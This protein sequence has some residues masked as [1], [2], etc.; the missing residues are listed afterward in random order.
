L[1]VKGEPKMDEISIITLIGMIC[2]VLSVAMLYFKSINSIDR[3]LTR[4]ETKTDLFWGMVEREIPRLLKAPT[5]LE[6]DDLLDK[7]TV[8]KLTKKDAIRLKDILEKE[9]DGCNDDKILACTL[10]LVRVEQIIMEGSRR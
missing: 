5:H 2:T 4:L 1:E 9:M 6:M 7:M 3:R 8:S 10:L